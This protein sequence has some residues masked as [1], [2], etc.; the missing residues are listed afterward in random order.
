MQQLLSI[1]E[2]LYDVSLNCTL[3]S[4]HAMATILS[5]RV[6]ISDTAA[7]LALRVCFGSFG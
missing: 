7:E 4:F 3:N 1:R 5:P 2:Q 6:I